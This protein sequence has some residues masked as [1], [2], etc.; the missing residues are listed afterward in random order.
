MHSV[1]VV[2]WQVLQFGTIAL[3]ESQVGG[4][5]FV[6]SRGEQTQLPPMFVKVSWQVVQTE[7]LLQIS[8]YCPQAEVEP[9][10]V[11]K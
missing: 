9:P 11:T 3:Q 8:Q 6:N 7:L 4:A 10:A 5:K 1:V 2:L